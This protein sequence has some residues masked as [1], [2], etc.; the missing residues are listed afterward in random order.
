MF[1]VAISSRKGSRVARAVAPPWRHVL[2]IVEGGLT[3]ATSSP[4]G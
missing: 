1:L 2:G 3:P 4:W